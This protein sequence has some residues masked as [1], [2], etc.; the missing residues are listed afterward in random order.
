[1]TAVK[2]RFIQFET[3]TRTNNKLK[4]RGRETERDESLKGNT[5]DS[6]NDKQRR[7]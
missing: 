4:R 2:S 7:I 6:G 5:N 1:M 3:D